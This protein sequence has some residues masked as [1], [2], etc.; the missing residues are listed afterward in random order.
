MMHDFICC[1]ELPS[2]G[3][4][5]ADLDAPLHSVL[6][7]EHYLS[8][9]PS[10]L[11]HSGVAVRCKTASTQLDLLTGHGGTLATAPIVLKGLGGA[12]RAQKCVHAL[13]SVI[14]IDTCMIRSVFLSHMI[15]AP[16]YS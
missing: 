7:G 1:E 2:G 13:K 6:Y 15:I 12:E 3:L 10:H 14:N 5:A 11:H 16:V 9:H 8:T 4:T